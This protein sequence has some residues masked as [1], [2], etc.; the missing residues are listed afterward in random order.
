MHGTNMKIDFRL[1]VL[2][3]VYL[4]SQTKGLSDTTGAPHD[5]RQTYA[6]YVSNK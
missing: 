4:Y 3:L 5:Y 6:I 2:E 1:L